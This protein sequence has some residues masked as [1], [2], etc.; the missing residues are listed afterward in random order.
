MA[1]P[2]FRRSTSD[3]FLLVRKAAYLFPLFYHFNLTGDFEK[4]FADEQSRR[5]DAD[6]LVPR[7][8]VGGDSEGEK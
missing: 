6:F 3:R 7:V 4:V 1:I 5:I 8:R 2:N